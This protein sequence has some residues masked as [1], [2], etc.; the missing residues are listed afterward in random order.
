M[1][2]VPPFSHSFS[3]HASVV[4]VF[5]EML[6]VLAVDTLRVEVVVEVLCAEVA[7]VAVELGAVHLQGWDHPLGLHAV[8]VNATQ[9]WVV[10]QLV[11]AMVGEAFRLSKTQARGDEAA[12]LLAEVGVLEGA[13]GQGM[14]DV[15][16]LATHASLTV[17]V[18]LLMK[19]TATCSQLLEPLVLVLGTCITIGR[20]A[21]SQQAAVGGEDELLADA[22]GGTSIGTTGVCTT[23]YSSYSTVSRTGLQ[24]ALSGG[25]VG[26]DGYS[27]EGAR[28]DG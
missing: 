1:V 26:L 5:T 15:V 16:A 18:A 4:I 25:G 2:T 20:S 11:M 22:Y 24:V 19:S 6:V 7:C 12:A 9:P 28:A 27:L 17:S 10:I 21:P 8:P 23:N 13:Q 3:L 14:T